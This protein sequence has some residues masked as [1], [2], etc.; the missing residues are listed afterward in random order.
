MSV[1]ETAH[2]GQAVLVELVRRAPVPPGRT[3]LMKFAY[4][5][6]VIRKVP[7][8]YRFR[9]YNY[10][11]YDQQVLADAREAE[12]NDLLQSKLVTFPKG[13]YGYEFLPSEESAKIHSEAVSQCEND[14]TWVLDQFGEESASRLELIST[15]VFAC[16]GESGR[17]DKSQLVDRVH[18]I[19]PHF[20][21]MQIGDTA[22]EISELLN[23][24]DCS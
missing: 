4:L 10:G 21:K 14:I 2:L 7:L 22:D 9:L 11:P 6:Q 13:G 8:G 24:V 20:T 5:L 12:A 18:E 3:T 23:C 17:L 19:K 16:C 15:L 1:S